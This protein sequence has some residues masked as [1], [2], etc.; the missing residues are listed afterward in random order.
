MADLQNV[1]EFLLKRDAFDFF[2]PLKSYSH[3]L[4]QA[5]VAPW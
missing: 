5:S 3:L 4:K 1:N 2:F